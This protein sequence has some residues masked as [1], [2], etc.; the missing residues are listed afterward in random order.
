M[1]VRGGGGGS[2]QLNKID[3]NDNFS[4]SGL[5]YHL[6]VGNEQIKQKRAQGQK[7]MLSRLLLLLLRLIPLFLLLLLLLLSRLLLLQPMM[8]TTMIIVMVLLLPLV[9]V[10]V[11]AMI[12][13]VVVTLVVVEIGGG[14]LGVEGEVGKE[15]A[16]SFKGNVQPAVKLQPIVLHIVPEAPS[17]NSSKKR[18]HPLT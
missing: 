3:R 7:G 15:G 6:H 14:S 13:V 8:M 18:N 11:L 12:M 10:V 5:Y 4:I 9:A 2:I 17:K 1:C 16:G